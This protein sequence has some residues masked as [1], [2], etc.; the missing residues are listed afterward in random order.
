MPRFNNKRTVMIE[1]IKGE[2]V[3]LTPAYVVVEAAGVGYRLH[4]S[5]YTHGALKAGSTATVYAY[6]AIRE[7]AHDLFGFVDRLER[8][9]FLQLISVSGVGS[10]TARM[11]LSTYPPAELQSLIAGGNSQALQSVKGV[12]AKTAQRIVVDLKDKLHNVAPVALGATSLAG[13]TS[14]VAEEAL[15]AL[16]ALGFA[17]P[18]ARKAVAA[19]LKKSPDDRVE[20]VIRTALK[21]L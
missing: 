12:G 18:A 6:E 20:L 15:A 4:I 16:T 8:Q 11:M 1:Y 10:Q 3:E 7:D 19:I 14:Q 17:A 21:M 5:L 2:V 13:A 9:L